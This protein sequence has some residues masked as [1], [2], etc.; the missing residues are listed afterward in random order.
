MDDDYPHLDFMLSDNFGNGSVYSEDQV[1]V[2]P[3]EPELA[4]AD[5]LWNNNVYDN[6]DDYYDEMYAMQSQNDQEEQYY[7]ELEGKD[8]FTCWEEWE[9]YC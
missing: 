2:G 4:S 5:S 1:V 7:V 8:I 6:D 9:D 3:D